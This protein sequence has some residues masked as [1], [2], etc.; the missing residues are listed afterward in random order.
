MGWGCSTP[1]VA[2]DM[3]QEW[4][5]TGIMGHAL[6]TLAGETQPAA[7]FALGPLF[8]KDST[9]KVG[10]SSIFSVTDIFTPILTARAQNCL[11]VYQ[12]SEMQG[13]IGF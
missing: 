13:D 2:C 9:W 6:R 4:P 1:G 11:Q 10:H 5:H 8:P 12:I 7:N 3:A